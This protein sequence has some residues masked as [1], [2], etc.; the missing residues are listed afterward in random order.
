ML[1]RVSITST[2]TEIPFF[3]LVL[4]EE[5]EEERNKRSDRIVESGRNRLIKSI[6]PFGSDYIGM[7]ED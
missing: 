6:S 3:S 4:R 2:S 1:P 7:H 5:G